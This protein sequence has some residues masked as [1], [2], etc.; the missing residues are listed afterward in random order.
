MQHRPWPLVVPV[1]V[2]LLVWVAPAPAPAA[3]FNNTCMV[4][5]GIGASLLFPYFEVDFSDPG[6]RTTL[7]SIGRSYGGPASLAR[8]TLWTDWGLPT[9][10]F[11]LYLKSGDIQTINLR[12]IFVTG[13]VPVTGPGANAL[14]GC[15]STI[16]GNVG[17][18]PAIIQAAHTGGGSQSPASG[19][20][21]FSGANRVAGFENQ[22]WGDWY[23]VTPSENFASGFN[24]VPIQADMTFFAAGDYTFYG[25]YIGFAATDKRRPLP[26]LYYHRFLLGGAFSGG[27]KMLVWRDTRS[28]AGAVACA[29]PAAQCGSATCRP[30][31]IPLGEDQV[32]AFD[33][34]GH[35][36]LFDNSSFFDVAVQKFDVDAIPHPY[37]FGFLRLDLDTSAGV[38]SQAWV[39]FESRA[40]GRFSV[41]IEGAPMPSGDNCNR[42]P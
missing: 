38:P 18:T 42:A 30:A 1:L 34:E 26:S 15:N 13:L 6:G 21:Y 5:L 4:N 33:E 23:L 27:T 2:A 41:G 37:D 20:S 28:T 39:G 10:A 32:R 7:I 14:A 8:V 36:T 29:S 22:L 11:T 9:A 12:D 19:A 35:T 31:W 24:A 25:K 16:G 40:E 3:T 17:I